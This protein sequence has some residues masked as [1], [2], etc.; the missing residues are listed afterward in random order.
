MAFWKEEARRRGKDQQKPALRLDFFP[1]LTGMR[2]W[3]A[4]FLSPKTAALEG[5]WVDK[6]LLKARQELCRELAA[7]EIKA[8][9]RH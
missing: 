5:F 3:A 7:L 1:H 9:P 8:R 6:S 4:S 2:Y